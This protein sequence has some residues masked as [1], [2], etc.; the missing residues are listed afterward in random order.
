[1]SR[2]LARSTVSIHAPLRGAT[3]NGP[4]SSTRSWVSIHAPLRGATELRR[5]HRTRRQKFQSTHPCGV[6]H[7]MGRDR[8]RDPGFQS[9]HPCGVRP[10]SV[11]EGLPEIC[12]SIHA[13]LR[14][15]TLGAFFVHACP[16]FV[17]IHAPL[18]GATVSKCCGGPGGTVSIHAPLRGATI[19]WANGFAHDRCF[20]PRTPA[21]CDRQCKTLFRNLTSFNPR[22]P[23]GCDYKKWSDSRFPKMFQSTHPCGV[24]RRFNPAPFPLLPC[25]NPRTP[26]GC[27]SAT[28]KQV[29]VAHVV[30][31]HAPLRG[32]TDGTLYNHAGMPMFQSTHPCG[33]RLAIMVSLLNVP[34]KFQSTHP[35]GVRQVSVSCERYPY[36]FQS[37]HPCGVRLC[38]RP[39]SVALGQV[40]IHAP[41]RGATRLPFGCL[42]RRSVSIHAPLRGATSGCMLPSHSSPCFNPR[43]PAGCDL[44]DGEHIVT[45]Y[46]F[47]PRTPAGCDRIV[48]G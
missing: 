27:D 7:Q 17:S 23:A 36:E 3:P 9:T 18:R 5:V 43:T 8:Q 45:D 26:A 39:D 2:F 47:N 1:M 4:G 12:V 30:S 46:S 13:P 40:S 20:N 24:R 29:R 21:G 25:F 31:I 16:P 6:R 44:Y 19:R 22:T 38:A 28:L 32:A 10:D 48:V 34:L 37:T 11:L 14:G 33:V 35:C 15:A 41:L 42:R